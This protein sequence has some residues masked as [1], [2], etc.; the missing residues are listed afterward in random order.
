MQGLGGR[1]N[2][3][4][5]GQAPAA[6][7][8]EPSAGSVRKESEDMRSHSSRSEWLPVPN[9]LRPFLALT[10]VAATLVSLAGAADAAEPNAVG[11]PAP[12]V[13]APEGEGIEGSYIITL[14]TGMPAAEAADLSGSLEAAA[15]RDGGQITQ[16]YR[17][18]VVGFAADLDDAAVERLRAVPSVASIHQ[19]QVMRTSDEQTNAPWGL[20]RIDQESR[21]LDSIY[22]YDETGAGVTVYVIDTGLRT[23]H[24]ELSGRVA[25]T[26]TFIGGTGDDCDGHGTHVAGTVAATTWG[27]AKQAQVYGLRVLGCN[28][29]GPLSGVVASLDWVAANAAKPAVVNMSLGGSLTSVLDT[30]LLSVRNSGVTV[31]VAAGN[32]NR[33]ACTESPAHNPNVITVASTAA[34]DARSGFSNWGSCVDIFGPGSSIRSLGINSDTSLATLSGTSMA[35]P[36]VAGVAALYLDA[37]PTATPDQVTAA[38]LGGAV[39]GKLSNIQGSPNLLLQSLLGESPPPPPPPPPPGDPVVS[40]QS[41]T[42]TE[43]DRSQAVKLT[44]ELDQPAETTTRVR[45]ATEDGTA[46]RNKDYN[47]RVGIITFRAGETSKTTNLV[48]R[49]DLNHEPTEQLQVVLSSPVGLELGSDGVITIE[50]NDLPGP[51]VSVVSRSVMET[52]RSQVIQ[53]EF[54]LDRAPTRTVRIRY[55]TDAGTA[56]RN[57]DYTHRGGTILFR[58]GET[59]KTA[60]IVIRGD[61]IVEPTETFR[62]ELSAPIGLQLGTG[63]TISII[64]ND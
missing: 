34:N 10:M 27:V 32:A 26:R 12:L 47:R 18:A 31:V 5:C 39:S 8:A 9:L 14:D 36:H 4:G 19:D 45:Y 53:V 33:D 58:A 13:L 3:T 11:T 61:V 54:T 6:A 30:A 48:I 40:V 49:G 41:M 51:T 60:N 22:R 43:T 57:R 55:L 38:I 50:D 64:D 44:F 2:V 46:L 21:P 20:D 62:I 37:N 56:T 24:Q 59:S 17:T 1:Y 15:Q 29:T 63:G 7:G 16:R 35:S 42:V 28:G 23:T 52:E 25:G